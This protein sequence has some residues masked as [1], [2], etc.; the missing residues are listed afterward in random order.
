MSSPNSEDFVEW[1]RWFNCLADATRLRILHFVANAD[2]PV[3][4]GHI[5]EAVGMSQSTVS[6]HLQILGEQQFVFS[7]ADGVRTLVW[8][9]ELCMT[10]LPL[11]AEAVM[12]RGPK[13]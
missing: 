2:A 5:V 11:A 12:G 6:R 7:E 1:A 13:P 3:T 10:E 8:A 4:V 9:N